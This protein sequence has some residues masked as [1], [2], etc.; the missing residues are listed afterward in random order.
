MISR[1][2]MEIEYEKKLEEETMKSAMTAGGGALKMSKKRRDKLQRIMRNKQMNQE[3]RDEEVRKL[4]E[5]VL[6]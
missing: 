5:E 4:E 1:K 2:K 6:D 3:E